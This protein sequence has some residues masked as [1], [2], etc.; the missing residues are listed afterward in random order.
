L[1]ADDKRPGLSDLRDSG[2]IE[3]DADVVGFIYRE[4]YYL[5][6]PG[7]R[8]PKGEDGDGRSEEARR[9]DM[10]SASESQMELI[11]AKNRQGP[12]G[13]VQL[14]CDMATNA[15]RDIA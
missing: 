4:H 3:Q 1:R 8:I 6:K 7:A 9:L 12:T 13:T 11:I 10:L 15:V 5:S 14:W 2:N